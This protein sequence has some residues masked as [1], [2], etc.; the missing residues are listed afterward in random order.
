MKVVIDIP[1]GDYKFIKDLQFYNSGR[2]SGKTIER[3]VINAIRNGTPLPKGH[4]DLIDK[5]IVLDMMNH[6]ILEEYITVMGG[7]IPADK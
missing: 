7:V 4:G 6:G 2:R 1:D 3:N 5:D